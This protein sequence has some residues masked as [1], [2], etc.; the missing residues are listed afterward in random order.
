[1]SGEPEL[2]DRLDAAID[3][4]ADRMVALFFAEARRAEARSR[5]PRRSVRARVSFDVRCLP[6]NTNASAFLD[7]YLR[8]VRSATPWPDDP[9][10]VLMLGLLGLLTNARL[11]E[12]VPPGSIRRRPALRCVS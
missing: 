9:A 11:V 5:R 8:A 4:F 6:A 1:M 12:G 7:G 2:R 3:D 10:W